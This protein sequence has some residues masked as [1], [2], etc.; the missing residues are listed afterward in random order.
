MRGRDFYIGKSP[1]PRLKR[2][3]PASYYAPPRGPL[4]PDA[5][6]KPADERRES[7]DI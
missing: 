7:P 5:T 2:I 4:Q 6:T 1:T 3:W